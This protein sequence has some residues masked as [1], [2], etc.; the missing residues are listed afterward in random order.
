MAQGLTISVY[1]VLVLGH[2]L[3]KGVVILARGNFL[4][5]E[6]LLIDSSLDRNMTSED[7]EDV[8]DWNDRFYMV[9]HIFGDWALY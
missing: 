6:L 1:F 4:G 8:L 2:I 7:S 9:W 3:L 5:D